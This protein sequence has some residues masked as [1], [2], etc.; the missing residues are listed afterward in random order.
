MRLGGSQP[1]VSSSFVASCMTHIQA[2]RQ[3]LFSLC[4]DA[5]SKAV[6]MISR[7]RC[8]LNY[9]PTEGFF[10]SRRA[11]GRCFS[12]SAIGL[13]DEALRGNS[14]SCPAD[15]VQQDLSDNLAIT[16][17]LQT[18]GESV[19]GFVDEAFNA[20]VNGLH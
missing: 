5:G 19:D 8:F 7:N 15:G 3:A 20:A 6:Y 10:V 17:L 14:A 1:L 2:H 9:T 11:V 4:I 16:H 18:H 13:L 12:S